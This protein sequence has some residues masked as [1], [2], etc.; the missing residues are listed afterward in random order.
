MQES[1]TNVFVLFFEVGLGVYVDVIKL[2]VSSQSQKL[3]KQTT[4]GFETLKSE[5]SNV[6]LDS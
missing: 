4:D 2:H 1:M 3:V 5:L 6:K